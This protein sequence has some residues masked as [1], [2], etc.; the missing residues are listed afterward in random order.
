M[1]E[2]LFTKQTRLMSIAICL[3]LTPFPG[4]ID[5]LASNQ[6]GGRCYSF[7]PGQRLACPTEQGF[8][9]QSSS[10]GADGG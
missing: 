4:D 5:H 2:N 6:V 8:E 3:G 7:P 10:R 1:Q 9:P